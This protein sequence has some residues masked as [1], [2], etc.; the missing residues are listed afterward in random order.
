[1]FRQCV[2]LLEDVLCQ[3]GGG[4]QKSHPPCTIYRV[5]IKYCVFIEDFQRFV[6]VSWPV[7]ICTLHILYGFFLGVCTPRKRQ[8][9][10]SS[11]KS[12]EGK[13]PYLMNT[14]YI[15][16]GIRLLRGM[17]MSLPPK[18]SPS[19]V[20]EVSCTPEQ[21]GQSRPGSP[22]MESLHYQIDVLIER[23]IDMQIHR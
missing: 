14:L 10:Q 2:Q 12:F 17:I 7:S 21:I 13:I 23:C 8:I 22:G 9:R 4:G 20:K 18:V 19:Q 11:E 15:T 3:K 1:M 6:L 16:Q 5:C